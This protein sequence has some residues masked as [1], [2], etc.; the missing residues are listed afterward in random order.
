MR[1]AQLIFEARV[2]AQTVVNRPPASEIGWRLLQRLT[3]SSPASKEAESQLRCAMLDLMCRGGRN[4]DSPDD[5]V[6]DPLEALDALLASP[7]DNSLREEFMAIARHWY[8]R[9]IAA[10]VQRPPR[11]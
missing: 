5:A 3:Y 10:E 7:Q 8:D 2:S 6:A 4:M 9:A 1:M 11:L